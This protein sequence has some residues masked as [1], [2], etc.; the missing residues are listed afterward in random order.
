[1]LNCLRHGLIVTLSLCFLAFGVQVLLSA[2][3][4][5]DPFSFV[6]TFFASNLIILIS[7]AVAVGFTLR[8]LR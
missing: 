4:L 7:A 5:Q 6:L 1:M 8:L 2:Y 3:Q